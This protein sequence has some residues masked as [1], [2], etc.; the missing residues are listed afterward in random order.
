[1]V[2]SSTVERERAEEQRTAAGMPHAGGNGS[3]QPATKRSIWARS[4]TRLRVLV[5]AG[6]VVLLAA[7]AFLYHHFAGWESTDDAQIDAYINPIS[8]RVAGYV[9]RVTVDN[10]VYVK[11]G[12][13][14]V[15]ID[16]RDYQVALDSAS[17]EYANDLASAQATQVNV[18]ITSV[19]TSSQIRTAQA[20]VSNAQAGIAAEEKQLE[21]AHASLAQAQA[22]DSKA[23][24]DVDRYKLLVAKN[25]ISQQQYSQAV[26]SARAT[27]A[28]VVAAQASVAAAERQVDQARARLI[29][30]EAEVQ[31]AL[32][33][34]HQVSAQ[35]SRARAAA[36]LVQ[37]AKSALEQAQLNLQYTTIVAPVDGIVDRRSV[38]VGQYVSPGQQL[39]S[40]VQI[41]NIWVTANFKE[42]QLRNMRA[43][44]GVVV[45]VDTYNHDYRARVLNIA[46]GSG[47]V[48]SLLPPE[49][50]TGNYVKV[51]Q[52]IPVKIVFERGQDPEHLLR[53]GMSVE[54][55]V[56][57]TDSG[58]DGIKTASLTEAN[59][60]RHG[61]D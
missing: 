8:P 13:V 3:R 38:Q 57:V 46:G 41:D 7:G 32:T 15:E 29:Q 20:G 23:Q 54:P 43:G 59:A 52:R 55:R 61:E 45:H 34:P 25:E 26:D 4:S 58:A 22:N 16:P 47:A 18:P 17:A 35:R 1:M 14:L 24:D 11:A 19:N 9:R 50:A 42:T 48:F 5:I 44:Q 30:A 37:R 39:M 40:I 6:A 21:A 60:R 27:H 12:T 49:N 28:A 2:E 36:A 10:N 33:G 56:R 51:V 31:S 53:P